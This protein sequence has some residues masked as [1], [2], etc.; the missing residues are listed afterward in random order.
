MKLVRV[1]DSREDGSMP[2]KRMN[3]MRIGEICYAIDLDV[4]VMAVNLGNG[5]T[6]KLVLGDNDYANYYG[7]N[8]EYTVR[9]LYHDECV[10]IDF[11]REYHETEE[12][13]GYDE[14]ED[15]EQDVDDMFIVDPPQPEYSPAENLEIH[16]FSIPDGLRAGLG[17]NNPDGLWFS[18]DQEEE[19]FREQQESRRREQESAMEAEPPPRDDDEYR[20]SCE[21]RDCDDCDDEECPDHSCNRNDEEEIDW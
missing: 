18:T 17:R 12:D 8:A 7:A 19:I 11:D 5:Q 13:N 16:P 15:R 3:Q 1:N 4:Y 10:T 2:V 14:N 20:D 21:D 9:G 6:A